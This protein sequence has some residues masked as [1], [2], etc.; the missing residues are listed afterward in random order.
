MI[1]ETKSFLSH[2]A[3][4]IQNITKAGETDNHTNH[5][6]ITAGSRA[7]GINCTIGSSCRGSIIRAY[8][9]FKDDDLEI[10]V[11]RAG[12]VVASRM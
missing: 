8:K 4:S 5:C 6:I 11:A 2:P 12:V 3:T 1:L 7:V 9:S 10:A